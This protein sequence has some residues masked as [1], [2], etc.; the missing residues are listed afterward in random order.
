MLN[1]SYNIA[2]LPKIDIPRSKFEKNFKHLTTF[3]VGKLVPIFV[4]EC[5]P[6]T[7]VNI[8]TN[9]L[10]R[11]QTLLSPIF[12]NLMMD[13]Y[14]FFVP[15]RLVWDHWKNFMG[16]NST[17]HWYPNVQ[18]QIPIVESE[19]GFEVNSIADYLGIPINVPNIEVNALPL[20][21]IALCWNEWFRDQNIQDPILIYTGDNDVSAT[22]ADGSAFNYINDGAKGMDLLPVD[23]YKDLFTTLLPAPQKGPS[24]ALN[25]E[26]LGNAGIVTY[27]YSERHQA[28]STDIGLRWN[29]NAP[30]GGS[31]SPVISPAGYTV[32]DT[33]DVTPFPEHY[34]LAYPLNLMA[35]ATDYYDIDSDVT[36]RLD[37]KL[38]M[39]VTINE[40][41]L[42]FATQ[43]L[44][45]RDARYGTRYTE[46][47]QGH[48]GITSPDARLQRPEFI[49][50]NHCHLYVDSVVQQ[51]ETGTTPL[52][53]LAAYSVTADSNDD[54]SAYTALEH[55][56]ILGFAC[57]RY[58]HTYQQGIDKMWSR[59]DR[60][61]YYWPELS[62]I[63]EVGVLGKELYNAVLPE[64]WSELSDAQKAA[65]WSSESTKRES[66]IGYQEAW[67]D[68]RFKRNIVSGEMH[69]G[70]SNT[71]DY[72]HLA[73]YYD[74]WPTPLSDGF[75][76]EDGSIV[77]RV[78][79]VSQ[80][81]S[82]QVMADF[83]FE[84][85]FV[86]PLPVYSIPGLID[87]R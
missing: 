23:K 67:Y 86:A 57:V 70:I 74:S 42:A 38:R 8:R 35:V 41:R 39:N 82:N 80:R 20:R 79:A 65:W 37:G 60:L 32:V 7:T 25:N 11:L 30:T 53:D 73:D 31:I 84:Y 2:E 15:Y 56:V 34:D 9:K 87:M 4:D 51:S 78:I 61:D 5:V 71:L 24:V 40:L 64:V 28:L 43:R 18:Y 14:F 17:G 16:E 10:V 62:N 49:G 54:V 59:R 29:K 13:T 68:M 1:D 3:D 6:G 66:V 81:V 75:I 47:I 26:I 36:G 12:D 58:E 52:G 44:L 72:W 50:G 22:Y 21:A 33:N 83:Y 55:G 19:E 48:F 77:D 63:G 85:D 46:V 76:R 27:D 45:E 69:S